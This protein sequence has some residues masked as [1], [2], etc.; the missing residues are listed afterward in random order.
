MAAADAAITAATLPGA[1][2]AL[3]ALGGAVAIAGQLSDAVGTALL[4]LARAAFVTGFRLTSAGHVEAG[5]PVVE[6]ASRGPPRSPGACPAD[7]NPPH[8]TH[9]THRRV[10]RPLLAGHPVWWWTRP[11]GPR[12]AADRSLF[13]LDALPHPVVPQGL[14]PARP[15]PR[16]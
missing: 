1:H 13:A 3:D 12:T 8:R 9:R 2:T 4:G 11:A 10:G 14:D 15:Y 5:E 7:G 6:A 16:R